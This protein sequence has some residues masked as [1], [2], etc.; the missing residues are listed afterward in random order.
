MSRL[1]ILAITREAR[2]VEF[3][4]LRSAFDLGRQP[5]PAPDRLEKRTAGFDDMS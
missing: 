3:G 1:G 4:F 2:K 5:V